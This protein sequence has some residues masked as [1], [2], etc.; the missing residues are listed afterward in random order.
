MIKIK[1]ANKRGVIKGE[2]SRKEREG[3]GVTG[4]RS[5]RRKETDLRKGPLKTQPLRRC[6]RGVE[7][8][9]RGRRG[10]LGE[11][12]KGTYIARS[13]DRFVQ[14]KLKVVRSTRKKRGMGKKKRKGRSLLEKK[15][16][17]PVQGKRN[18]VIK[19]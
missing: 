13:G 16:P 15:A 18:R 5:R 12:G 9:N 1:E 3:G 11:G 19:R 2:V 14:R 8:K 7:A 4:R 10:I 6:G 17:S